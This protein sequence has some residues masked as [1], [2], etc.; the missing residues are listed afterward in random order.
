MHQVYQIKEFLNSA[1]TNDKFIALIHNVRMSTDAWGGE[2]VVPEITL[3]KCRF[4]ENKVLFED[5]E[6]F[7]D[8]LEALE[9]DVKTGRVQIYI[10]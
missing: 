8:T 2:Y 9:R 5:G 4:E 7:H 1:K 10:D 3:E 6:I